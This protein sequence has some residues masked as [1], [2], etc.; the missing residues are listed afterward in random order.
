MTPLAL[1]TAEKSITVQTQ[2]VNDISTPCLL[3]C[4]AVIVIIL[5]VY[6]YIITYHQVINSELYL[7][8]NTELTEDIKEHGVEDWLFHKM[9]VF[10]FNR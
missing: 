9:F 4:V 8:Q 2:T 5:S 3:V 10:L 6:H 7:T 1:S